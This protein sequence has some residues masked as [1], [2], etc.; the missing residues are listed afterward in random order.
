MMKIIAFQKML[1]SGSTLLTHHKFDF[2]SYSHRVPFVISW[3]ICIKTLDLVVS[4]KIYYK[5]INH[6][7][8]K[9][10]RKYEILFY[11]ILSY[12]K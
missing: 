12:S 2:D 8:L 5:F 3:P 1:L 9:K 6:Y 7:V 10:T 4:E 11:E